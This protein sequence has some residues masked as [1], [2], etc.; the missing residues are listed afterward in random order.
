MSSIVV[1]GDTS[2]SVT[3]A[4]PAVA[5]SGTLTLPTGTDTLV[6][7][8]TTDT[9][10]NKTLTSPVLTAPA[11]GTVAS[12]VISACTSNGMVLTAP[13]LGTVASG[14]LTA[15]TAATAASGT[16]TTALAT[17]AFAYGT[18]SNTTSGYTKLANGLI[19]QWGTT[20]SI[21]VGATS[22][23]TLPIAFPT[24][25]YNV[26]ITRNTTSLAASYTA[27]VVIASLSAFTVYNNGITSAQMWTAVG[28]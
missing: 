7:K 8:A 9:L 21:G 3:I 11:L 4:A 22:T 28:I 24:T 14:V 27:A 15:C 6:G 20:G 19:L 2:G 18:L 10:T 1:A 25:F 12:G 23:I 16:N 26:G 13:A 5:G 17:T